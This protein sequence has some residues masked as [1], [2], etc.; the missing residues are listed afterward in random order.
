M[1]LL[2][3]ALVG[4]FFEAFVVVGGGE[5]LGDGCGELEFE[6]FVP[7]IEEGLE[8]G[9]LA[10]E[11]RLGVPAEL[12]AGFGEVDGEALDGFWE[13]FFDGGG[14]DGLGGIRV[15]FDEAGAL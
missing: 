12:I 8:L 14:I 4:F 2:D 9:E 10:F 15:V 5:A 11:F 7:G 13:E 3:G 1:F 6:L